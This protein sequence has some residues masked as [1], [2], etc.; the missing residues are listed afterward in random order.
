MRSIHPKR[1]CFLVAI[2]FLYSA[3]VSYGASNPLKPRLSAGYSVPGQ[4]PVSGA[5]DFVCGTY[6]GNEQ[7]SS[8]FYHQYKAQAQAASPA[9]AI[10]HDDVWV[11]EDDGT[12]LF[13]GLNVF[14]TD[15]QTFRFTPN[16]VGGYDVSSIGFSFDPALGT[17]LGLGDDTNTTVG[18]LFTFNYF[19]APWSD[20][21]VNSNGIIGFGTDVNPTGFF[22]SNDFFSEISKIAA[23]FMDLNP[24][25]GGA[26]F[27]K[28]EATRS[29]FT[30]NGIPEFDTGNL[31]TIQLVLHDTGAIDATF[32]GIT[33]TVAA[34]GAPITFGIHPGGTPGLEIISFSNDLPFSGAVFTGIYENYLNITQPL[35]N[36]VALMKKF[37][38]SFPVYF[39]QIIFF[40]YFKQTIG[41]F[42]NEIN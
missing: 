4:S 34:N 9:A 16:G 38:Q 29:T 31:N 8:W 20:V 5:N 24:A 39:F 23:Y 41:V 36:E 6:K 35:V 19:G 28:A 14:D 7:G 17:N 27:H 11:V 15:L 37:Y 2:L 12:L 21:H 26:V 22:D 25:A 33:S 18:L 13:S 1:L 32:N 10:I 40:T 42:A 3:S 30:W